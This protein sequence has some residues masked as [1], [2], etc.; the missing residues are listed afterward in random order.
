MQSE[1]PMLKIGLTGGIGSGKTTVADRFKDYGIPVIDA[2]RVAHALVAPGQPALVKIAETFGS[3]LLDAD[4]SLNRPKMRELIFNSSALRDKL[5]AIL[6]PRIFEEID[7][8]LKG[9]EAPY[10]IISIPLLLETGA[11]SFVD[12]ILVVDCPVEL[13]YERVAARDKLNR[14]QIARILESQVS[15]EMRVNAA[16]EIIVNDSNLTSL[17][18]QVKKIHAFYLTLSLSGF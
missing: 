12:R 6:H 17:A 5:E 15:R 10:V 14:E 7:R 4:G 1:R 3:D 13:Q 16:D 9:V 18:G 2:D 8:Q 11:Q